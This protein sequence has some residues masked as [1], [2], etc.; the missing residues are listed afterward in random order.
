MRPPMEKIVVE[1]LYKI[2]GKQPDKALKMLK[3]GGDKDSISEKIGVI[4]FH[5]NEWVVA[6]KLKG[7]VITSP[8]ISNA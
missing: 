3:E 4:L 1:N 7:V 2:F 6:T 8:F 5:H